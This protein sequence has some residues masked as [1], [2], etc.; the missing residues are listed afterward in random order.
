MEQLGFQEDLAVG[1]GDD[2]GWNISGNV[3]SLRFNN[4]QSCQRAA[5]LCIAQFGGTFQQT[6]VQVENIA[7]ICFASRRTTNQQRQS[8]VGNRMFGKVIIDNK[9]MLTLIHKV[10]AH[11]AA[12]IRRNILQGRKLRS[13][14]AHYSGV[15]HGSVFLEVFNQRGHSRTLLANS[16]IDAKDIFAFLVDDRIRSNH[17]LTGLAVADNQLTLAAA[18]GNH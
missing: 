7:G 5:A 12:G 2:V 4:G 18:N 15:S 10:F 8:T 6:A 11:G 17:S 1:N 16:N 3:T 9:H 14:G 13:C